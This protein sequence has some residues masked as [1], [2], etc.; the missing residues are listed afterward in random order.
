MSELNCKEFRLI[1]TGGADAIT[2][3][4]IDEALLG[5]FEKDANPILRVYSW[6]DSFTLGVSQKIKDHQELL[7]PN[8]SFAKRVTG[9]GV[10]FHGHDV[11]YSV[12]L[13]SDA[14]DT[15]DVKQSYE[16]LC[17][18]LITFYE[19]LGLIPTFAKD[20][21]ATSASSS[22]YCQVGFE[23]YDILI[24]G[25]KIGGNAQRRMKDK[26]FQH[27]SIPF[28]KNNTYKEWQGYNLSDFGIELEEEE[29][30]E[31]LFLAF[32]KTFA[33][34]LDYSCFSEKEE[35]LIT[36][37]IKEKYANSTQEEA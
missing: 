36:A 9:G 35:Q 11:S 2:N 5:C 25:K 37:L 6:S 13:P 33:I 17:S 1:C 26:I 19:D 12:V 21:K 27:G 23:P 8:T 3:M 30:S 28:R 29:L 10:L 4:A 32:H 18:F 7:Q 20:E 16:K 34:P 31:K 15:L 24:E 22:P 14:F